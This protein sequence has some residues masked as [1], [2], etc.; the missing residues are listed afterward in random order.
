MAGDQ[1]DAKAAKKG[2]LAIYV[3]ILIVVVAALTTIVIVYPRMQD[4]EA[5]EQTATS[6]TNSTLTNEATTE[7]TTPSKDGT[8]LTVTSTGGE[9]NGVAHIKATPGM[10]G[11]YSAT[12]SM[13][14]S[15]DLAANPEPA[16][17]GMPIFGSHYYY[18]NQLVVPEDATFFEAGA[19]T[20]VHCNKGVLLEDPM[21]AGW[22]QYWQ[23][24]CGITDSPSTSQFYTWFRASYTSYDDVLTTTTLRLRDTSTY[25]IDSDDGSRTLDSET[26]STSGSVVREYTLILAE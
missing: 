12:Y 3:G 19:L 22:T 17:G 24:E 7:E 14:I 18:A 26:G 20:A 1:P 2:R 23:G 13:L 11:H 4:D 9:I 25:W 16:P 6:L 21:T 10:E 8:T 5:A 15:D